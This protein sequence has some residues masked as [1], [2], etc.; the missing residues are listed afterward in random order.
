MPVSSRMEG[1]IITRFEQKWDNRCF[2]QLI[3]AVGGAHHWVIQLTF[4][5]D[6][7]TRNGS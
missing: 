3:A 5:A 1:E 4:Q 7:M 6:E 2:V